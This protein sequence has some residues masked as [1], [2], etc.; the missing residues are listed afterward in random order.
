MVEETADDKGAGGPV[1]CQ[2]VSDSG[3]MATLL[4]T[5]LSD[6]CAQPCCQSREGAEGSF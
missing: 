2:A 6:H 4:L 1:I 5:R 3:V